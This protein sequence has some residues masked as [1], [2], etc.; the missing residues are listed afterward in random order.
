MMPD[1][2]RGE[3]LRIGEVAKLLGVS[4][5]C[6]RNWERLGLVTPARSEGRYRL[7]SR[8]AVEDLKHVD[9]L[10]RVRR[11]NPRGIVNLRKSDP[12]QLQD[13]PRNDEVPVRMGIG[14]RLQALRERA[15]LTVAEAS[16]RSGCTVGFINAVERGRVNA[17]VA[18]LKQLA[19]VCGG[20]LLALFEPPPGSRGLVRPRDRQVMDLEQ[21]VRMELLAFGDVQM[22]PYVFRIA[23]R[24]SSGGS[25]QHDGE[26]FMYMLQGQLEIWLDE[27]ERYVLH[28]GDSLYF[29]SNR[30]HRWRC[31]GAEEAVVLWINLPA[32]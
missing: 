2:A 18:I 21:G 20:S 3:L 30:P 6:L 13:V 24:A 1:M 12:T 19:R 9:Y 17:S 11:V 10:R 25:Y 16:A 26:E 28:P 8:R 22:R 23:A 27:V 4:A 15:G 7:Y 14:K 31:V 29:L 32:R 5:S